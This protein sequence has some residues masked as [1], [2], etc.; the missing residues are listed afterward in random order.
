MKHRSKS[1][2]WQNEAGLTI[3]IDLSDKMSSYCVRGADGEIRHEDRVWTGAVQLSQV[4]GPVARSRIVLEVGTHSPWVS[5]LL[6]GMGHEVI[7]ANPRRLQ[8]IT[9]NDRKSDRV[10]AA[11][12]AELGQAMP[13]LLNPVRHRSAEAQDDLMLIRARAR[14]VETRT[15]LW[16]CLR[17]LAKTAGQRFPRKVSW[18]EVQQ[19]DRALV[20]I[21]EMIVSATEKIRAY[22]AEIEKLVRTKYPA[23]LRLQQVTGVGPI[24]ALTFVLTIDYPDRFRRSRDVGS[25][26][27]LRP[28]QRDSGESQPQLRITRAG[29]RYLRAMLVQGAQYILH[30]RGPDTDLKRWGLRLASRGGRAGKKRAVVA[31]ARKLAVLLHRLWVSGSTYEP[32][33]NSE[34]LARVAG[35]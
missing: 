17:G 5:R 21:W 2:E 22:D 32:L 3:G 12:L 8:L 25:Y 16:N 1:S 28:R 4:F 19:R 23:A 13:R 14:L 30:S 11:L 27:G 33:R 18:A 29:D 6:E 31:V 7:V 35:V 10:D 26:L 15:K 24:I 34:E 20:P 9:K